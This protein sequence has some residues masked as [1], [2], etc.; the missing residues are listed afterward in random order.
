MFRISSYFCMIAIAFLSTAFYAHAE[1]VNV[2]AAASMKT[3]LDDAACRHAA[4]ARF[5]MRRG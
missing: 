1:G 5:V 3:A 2:F 4:K